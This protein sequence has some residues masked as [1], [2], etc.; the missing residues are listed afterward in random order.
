MHSLSEELSQE[1]QD[2]E[3]L[4]SDVEYLS[5][6]LRQSTQDQDHT[7]RKKEELTSDLYKMKQSLEEQK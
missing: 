4:K 6:R 3:K 1:H 7:N 5:T 2:V